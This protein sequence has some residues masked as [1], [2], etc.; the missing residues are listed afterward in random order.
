M[1]PGAPKHWTALGPVKKK[2]R[3]P[4]RKRASSADLQ[5]RVMTDR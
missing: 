3:F 1:T 2:A 4:K 5:K